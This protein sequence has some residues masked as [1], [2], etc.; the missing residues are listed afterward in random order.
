MEPTMMTRLSDPSGA[1]WMSGSSRLASRKWP[2]WLVPAPTHAHRPHQAA[3]GSN[4]MTA[5]K[6]Q[7]QLLRTPLVYRQCS[8]AS[9]VALHD[10]T[11]MPPGAA[12]PVAGRAP[13]LSS[14]PSAV[15]RGCLAVGRYTAALQTSA[16]SRRPLARNASTNARTESS[17]ARSRCIT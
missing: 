15:K 13:V 11:P 14:K 9:E 16:S 10:C 7:A 1:F 12:Q 4:T 17:A 2:R 5:Y 6:E 3:P 8:P